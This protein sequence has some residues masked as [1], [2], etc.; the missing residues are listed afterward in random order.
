M[1]ADYS[2]IGVVNL[3]HNIDTGK[4]GLLIEPDTTSYFESAILEVDSTDGHGA[5][6]V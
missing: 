2:N 5:E 1:L 6:D 4:T 3:H